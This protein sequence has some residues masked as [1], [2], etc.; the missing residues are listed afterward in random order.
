[1]RGVLDAEARKLTR[2][3]DLV[4]DNAANGCAANYANR[5]AA[6]QNAANNRAGASADS[7]VTVLVRHAGATGQAECDCYQGCA[8]NDLF[9]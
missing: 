1:M 5:A 8:D 2:G 4:T 6:G 3:L 9:C 7:G